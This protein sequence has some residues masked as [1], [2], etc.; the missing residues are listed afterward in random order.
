MYNG[1]SATSGYGIYL[2]NGRVRILA[3]G[4]DWAT[5]TTCALA[6]GE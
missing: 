6:Q 5:C 4:V 2:E 1:N 3:G